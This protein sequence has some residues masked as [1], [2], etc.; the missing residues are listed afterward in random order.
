KETGEIT[1]DHINPDDFSAVL[2]FVYTGVVNITPKTVQSLLV[3]AN[4]LQISFLIQE[5]QHFMEAKLDYDNIFDV[6]RFA[7]DFSLVSLK[8]KCH[9]FIQKNLETVSK[10]KT[11]LQADPSLIKDVLDDDNLAV[12][13]CLAPEAE[14]VVLRSVLAYLSQGSISDDVIEMLLSTVRFPDIA[15][16]EVEKIVLDF[17]TLIDNKQLMRSMTLSVKFSEIKNSKAGDNNMNIFPES[18]R[19][20]RKMSYHMLVMRRRRYGVPLFTSRLYP[21]GCPESDKEIASVSIWVKPPGPNSPAVL[22]GLVVRY[23]ADGTS[24]DDHAYARGTFRDEWDHFLLELSPE[25]FIIEVQIRSTDSIVSSI[26]FKMSSG[27]SFGPY[28]GMHG[29]ENIEHAPTPKKSYLNA[30]L[31]DAVNTPSLTGVIN[32]ALRWITF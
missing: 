11:F 6:L 28:G 30:I 29:N 9:I 1:L 5:C 10:T 24:C 22:G 20:P 3:A 8:Q 14:A 32:L 31:C 13:R 27:R 17:P 18:W 26:G 19:K 16:K 23:R 2:D 4:Y 21:G 7:A 25:E 15:Q 12:E